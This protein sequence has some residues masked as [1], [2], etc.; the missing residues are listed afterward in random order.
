MSDLEKPL[1]ILHLSAADIMLYPI[2]RDQ[3]CYLREQGY[4]IH[5][6]SI[7]GP[8]AHRLRDEDGFP[9]TAL[10][11]DREVAPLKDWRAVRFVERLCREQKF[12]I[13]HTHTPKGN[14]VGQWGARRALVPIVLQTL[15]GFYF[16]ENMS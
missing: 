16:H 9:W 5:T 13:V 4:E 7:D 14:L 1:K 10:P 2:L 11:F 12:Q 8:L 6:A 3:L 15:H